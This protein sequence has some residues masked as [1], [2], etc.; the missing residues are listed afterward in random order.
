MSNNEFLTMEELIRV[1]KNQLTRRQITLMLEKGEIP[2]IKFLGHWRFSKGEL[3]RW[4]D[5]KGMMRDIDYVW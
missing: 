4:M 2:G 5:E 1:L 3:Q